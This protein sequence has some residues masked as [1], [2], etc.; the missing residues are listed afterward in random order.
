MSRNTQ[1]IAVAFFIVFSSVDRIIAATGF[2]RLPVG[3]QHRRSAVLLVPYSPSRAGRR[4]SRAVNVAARRAGQLASVL[5][6]LPHGFTAVDS[7]GIK[8]YP[9]RLGVEIIEIDLNLKYVL[10]AFV[11]TF[12]SPKR[13]AA[14][15]CSRVC[16][17]LTIC[18][19]TA[20]LSAARSR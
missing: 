7:V 13:S 4:H 1:V 11:C 20:P 8:L 9:H 5:H 3:S 16:R 15:F 19:P 17:Q 18:L 2:V 12:T 14:H 6:L 10:L